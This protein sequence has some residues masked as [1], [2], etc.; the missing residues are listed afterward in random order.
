ML[1]NKEK[2]YLILSAIARIHKSIG[3]TLELEEVAHIL[4]N[5]LTN[6]LNCNACA[7]LLLECESIRVVAEK[8]FKK[9]LGNIELTPD[10]PAI[11]HIINTKKSIYTNDLNNSLVA[12]CVPQG[13]EMQSIICTPVIVD[14]QVKGI[15]HIDAASKGAFSEEDLQFVEILAS[16]I[17]IAVK[18]SILYSEVKAQSLKDCLTGCYNRRKFDEDIVIDIACSNRHGR[19]LSLLMIDIDWFKNYNDYHGHVKGDQVLKKIGRLFKSNLRI[20]DRVY[21]YGGEEFAILLP[22][23]NKDQA[24]I[25][26][27]RLRE[28]VYNEYFEGES[29]SQPNKKITISIGIATYPADAD[30]IEKLI[31]CADIALYSSKQNGRNRITLYSK[32]GVLVL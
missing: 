7:F 17:S 11:R 29:E 13:C 8:G 1:N 5:E 26:A 20:T 16:E 27:E 2:E 9:M 12:S 30:S 21:R 31:K 19:P 25:V 10:F 18:R 23:T 28:K 3:A 4:V 6:I 24:I 22:E 32:E 15:I 14:D